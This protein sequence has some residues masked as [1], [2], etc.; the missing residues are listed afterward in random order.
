MKLWPWK[1]L[2][3]KHLCLQGCKHK[4]LATKAPGAA[5]LLRLKQMVVHLTAFQ[6]RA[7]HGHKAAMPAASRMVLQGCQ[8]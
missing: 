3:A 8:G 6:G 7:Q 1:L 5:A 4:S 2:V